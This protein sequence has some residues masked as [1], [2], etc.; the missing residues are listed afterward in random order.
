[1]INQSITT[2]LFPNKITLAKVF[3]HLIKVILLYLTI[4]TSQFLSYQLFKQIYE[5]TMFDQ[6]REYFHSNKL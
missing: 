2:D 3:P 5:R 6:L 1:M 4:T